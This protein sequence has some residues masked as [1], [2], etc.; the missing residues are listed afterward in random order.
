M[1]THTDH[2][3][4]LLAEDLNKLVPLVAAAVQAL[5][6]PGSRAL[7]RK[8]DAEF[9]CAVID[10][11]A[12]WRSSLPVSEAPLGRLVEYCRGTSVQW[13]GRKPRE[14]RRLGHLAIVG[15]TD[16]DLREGGHE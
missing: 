10:F 1:R 5:D 2:F 16:L 11:N 15:G 8:L 12:A 4:G 3:L 13:G 6:K 9:N 7:R 14:V